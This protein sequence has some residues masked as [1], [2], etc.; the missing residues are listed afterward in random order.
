MKIPKVID[1]GGGFLLE[2]TSDDEKQTQK[3]VQ[4]KGNLKFFPKHYTYIVK[5]RT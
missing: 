3:I 4:P 5:K 2:E 1:T